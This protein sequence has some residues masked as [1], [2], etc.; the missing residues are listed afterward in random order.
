MHTF[1]SKILMFEENRETSKGLA[2]DRVTVI[3]NREIELSIYI[4]LL[5]SHN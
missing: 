3:N 5:L 4:G 2:A 1:V